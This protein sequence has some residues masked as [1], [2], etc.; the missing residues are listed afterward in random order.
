M[1]FRVLRLSGREDWDIALTATRK[2]KFERNW[3]IVRLQV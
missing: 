3:R 1:G 2:N